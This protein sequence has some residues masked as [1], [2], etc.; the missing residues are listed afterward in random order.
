MSL[1]SEQE[2]YDIKRKSVPYEQSYVGRSP[3]FNQESYKSVPPKQY[4]E[5][6]K[7][8][9]EEQYRKSLEKYPWLNI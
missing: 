4:S 9:H 5:K 6:E 8:E 2:L 1:P 3:L 7:L